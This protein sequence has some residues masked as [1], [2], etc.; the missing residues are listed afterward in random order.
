METI[1]ES[2]SQEDLIRNDGGSSW[3]SPHTAGAAATSHYA[4]TSS[5]T[6]LN[7]VLVQASVDDGSHSL[8][9]H[10]EVVETTD[11]KNDSKTAVKEYTCESCGATFNNSSNLK[12]HMRIHSG[13][14]PYVCD[15][16]NASFVQVIISTLLR[17]TLVYIIRQYYW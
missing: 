3:Y 1:D 2:H 8:D 10:T 7:G 4:P 6:A 12:S 16:C 9:P 17:I 11:L 13:E 14:R 15:V 5:F